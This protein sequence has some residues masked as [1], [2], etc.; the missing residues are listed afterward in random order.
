MTETLF[1]NDRD[2]ARHISQVQKKVD[3]TSA[4]K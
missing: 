3:K 2:K 1:P 4:I